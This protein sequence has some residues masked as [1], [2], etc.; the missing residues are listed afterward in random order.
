MISTLKLKFQDY[1]TNKQITQII[2][3]P[4]L[5]NTIEFHYFTIFRFF[6]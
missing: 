3:L 4:H 2:T 6:N 5:N 1:Q